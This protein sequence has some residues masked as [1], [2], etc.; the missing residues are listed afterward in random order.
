MG[1]TAIPTVFLDRALAI[2]RFTPS[3]VPI[4][5]LMPGDLGRPL[6]HL[7]HSL[8]YPELIEDAQQVLATLIPR[9]REV[10]CHDRWLLA[11]LQ[12]Y[13]TVDD[14]IA[15]VVLTLVDVT[16]LNRATEGLRAS[17]ERLRLLVEGVTDWAIFTLDAERRIAIWNSG[18]ELLFGYSA[19]EIV[20]RDMDVLLT[21][22]RHTE[23]RSESDTAVLVRRALTE[24]RASTERWY[25]RK[26]GST[27]FGSGALTPLRDPDGALRGYAQILHDLTE[28]KRSA[29]ALAEQMELLTRFNQAAVGRELRMRDLKQ[30][31]NQL[32]ARLGEAPKYAVASD[33]GDE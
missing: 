24:G 19:A 5:N 15:G 29:D 32:A 14:R 31:V 30:E 28:A 20:G 11:R 21:P 26:D 9:D 4:F 10:A 22:E 12:P 13:R 1:A 23:D 7:Q 6:A 16:A 25:R 8:D 17:E 3:A 18:A 2:T 33:V 27:F